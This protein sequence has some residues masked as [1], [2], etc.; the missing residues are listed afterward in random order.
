MKLFGFI[1]LREVVNDVY[2]LKADWRQCIFYYKG[3][4]AHIQPPKSC[5][6]E[7]GVVIGQIDSKAGHFQ[8]GIKY[9]LGL[10]LSI[11]RPALQNPLLTPI[12]DLQNLTWPMNCWA[13]LL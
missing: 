9:L 13:N 7:L 11:F 12:I 4:V 10:V 6:E 8:V 3:N 2:N 1:Y 5:I